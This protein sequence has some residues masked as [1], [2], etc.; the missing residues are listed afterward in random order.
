MTKERGKWKERENKIKKDNKLHNNRGKNIH[1]CTT[2]T[3]LPYNSIG[4]WTGTVYEEETLETSDDRV[5]WTEKQP[6]ENPV[7]QRYSM[8]YSLH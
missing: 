8:S 4:H 5:R 1:V 6:N 3:L 2:E 7:Q